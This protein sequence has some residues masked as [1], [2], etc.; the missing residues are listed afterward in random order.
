LSHR[1]SIVHGNA[2]ENELLYL[3]DTNWKN[4]ITNKKIVLSIV[5]HHIDTV[6]A[7]K[8]EENYHI[9]AYEFISGMSLNQIEVLCQEWI[10]EPGVILFRGKGFLLELYKEFQVALVGGGFYGQTHSILEP[11]LAGCMVYCGPHIQRSSEY[12]QVKD[13]DGQKLCSIATMEQWRSECLNKILNVVV[14]NKEGINHSTQVYQETTL[15]Q[16]KG[17]LEKIIK[18]KLEN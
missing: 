8:I 13:L 17:F 15:I 5:A 6:T 3:A 4:Y 7:K 18:Q 16:A 11:Y 2:Y 9:K 10:K 14:D 1:V 12:F